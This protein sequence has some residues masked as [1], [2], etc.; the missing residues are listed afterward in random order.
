MAKKKRDLFETDR[1]V[2]LRMRLAMKRAGEGENNRQT[3][4]DLMPP[5]KELV[6][7]VIDRVRQL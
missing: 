6:D 5:D 3:S 7:R 4:L 2:E 1:R